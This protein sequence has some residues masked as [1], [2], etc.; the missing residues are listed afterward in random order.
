GQADRV[1]AR[2]E[3]AEVPVG[4]VGN[5][6]DGG[7]LPAGPLPAGPA[8]RA[9][10][11]SSPRAARGRRRPRS[12]A[13]CGRARAPRPLVRHAS[14][15]SA[16]SRRLRP[17]SLAAGA[18][19]ALALPA[20]PPAV[21]PLAGATEGLKKLAP[22]VARRERR[23]LSNGTRWS[24]ERGEHLVGVAVDLDPVPALLDL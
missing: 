12:A 20:R 8:R 7:G 24:R 3:R 10:G 16:A 23:S 4:L 6:R 5:V 19:P 13:A 2:A 1:P 15:P 21:A 14:D 18:A 22:S 9:P 11:A 17:G